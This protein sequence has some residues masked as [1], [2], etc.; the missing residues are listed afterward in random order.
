MVL[1][2]IDV[3]EGKNERFDLEQKVYEMDGHKYFMTRCRLQ[4]DTA[5]LEINRWCVI[6]KN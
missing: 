4:A 1:S 6:I 2:Y 5:V 3:E